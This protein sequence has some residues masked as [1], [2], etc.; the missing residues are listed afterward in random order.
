[1]EIASYFKSLADETRLRILNLLLH[2][3][4]NVNEIVSV[5]GMG[6]S[7]VS[8]HLKILADSGF[9][10][11]RRDGLWAFY[12]A[13]DSGRAGQ[14]LQALTPMFSSDAELSR[15]LES[16]EL[17]MK[18]GIERKSR[19]FDA[20]ATEWD[21]MKNQ[22]LGGLDLALEIVQRIDPCPVAADIGCGTGDLLLQL[23]R[24]ATR[25]IGVDNSPKMLEEASRRLADI[26]DAVELRLGSIEHLPMRD[27]EM[28]A[29][30]M[31]MVLH[32]VNGPAEAVA[33]AGRVL[34][35]GGLLIIADLDKHTREEMRS[36][37]NHR[38]LGFDGDE[39]HQWLG[40]AGFHLIEERRY[41]VTGGLR[42]VLYR[43]VK[44]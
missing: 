29:A 18:E 1:M 25:V 9:L 38:W 39:V 14:L 24:R 22:I 40:H 13:S 36:V 10:S 3:E 31:N 7:R 8:R 43:A 35:N 6:Q 28:D 30:V 4:L 15:D 26:R 32:H 21:Y 42:A 27:R 34:K 11:F 19:Y 37:Y 20:I 41:D 23:S 33:E 16:L 17:M 12:R 44:E 2:H 5:M